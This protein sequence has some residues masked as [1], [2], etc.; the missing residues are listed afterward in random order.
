MFQKVFILTHTVLI[1]TVYIHACNILL[2]AW[3]EEG[4]GEKENPPMA[5]LPQNR[6]HCKDKNYKQKTCIQTY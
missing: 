4:D 3:I 2:R 5:L 6:N 1:R